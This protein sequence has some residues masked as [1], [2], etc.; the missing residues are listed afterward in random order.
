MSHKNSMVIAYSIYDITSQI[1]SLFTNKPATEY[2]R[3]GYPPI[4]GVIESYPTIVL[5]TLTGLPG[6]TL[7]LVGGQ[8]FPQSSNPALRGVTLEVV[9]GPLLVTHN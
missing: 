2:H 4:F 3:S 9:G 1:Y 8:I 7:V 5:P 6:V